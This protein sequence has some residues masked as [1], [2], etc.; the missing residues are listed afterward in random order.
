M[1]G[2]NTMPLITNLKLLFLKQDKYYWKGFLSMQPLCFSWFP[3]VYGS[4]RYNCHIWSDDRWI[5][6]DIKPQC[7]WWWQFTNPTVAL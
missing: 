6:G 7:H 2:I 3:K 1:L 5:H 4:T